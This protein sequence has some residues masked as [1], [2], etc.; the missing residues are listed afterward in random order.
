VWGKSFLDQRLPRSN[1]I[2]NFAR[3]ANCP[4]DACGEILT[5]PCHVREL[6]V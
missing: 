2:D 1:A 6:L 4:F 3:V 5:D